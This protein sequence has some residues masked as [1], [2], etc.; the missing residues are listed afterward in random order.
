MFHYDKNIN[1]NGGGVDYISFG[2]G[3]K[4]LIIVPGLG[5][6]IKT[7]RGMYFPYFFKYKK[8]ASKYKIFIFSRRNN[9]SNNFSTDDMALDIVN[10]MD[11]LNIKSASILGIS[12]G[13][14]IA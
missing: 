4:Y 5:D 1:V 11:L 10:T 3:D 6:G 12:Q 8:L 13:G 2:K 7:V 14:M 9:I